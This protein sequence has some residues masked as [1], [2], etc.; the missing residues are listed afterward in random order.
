MAL[1]MIVFCLN[2]V[3]AVLPP[4]GWMNV[5]SGIFAVVM[6]VLMIEEAQR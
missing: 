5:V 2:A 3:F 6:A 4:Y 1:L